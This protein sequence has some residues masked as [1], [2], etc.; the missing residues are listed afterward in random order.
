[1]SSVAVRS[2][3][4]PPR[5]R[6]AVQ[7]AHLGSHPLDLFTKRPWLTR[8]VP[9]HRAKTLSWPREGGGI[10]KRKITAHVAGSILE[11]GS[12]VW[13]PEEGEALIGTQRTGI[14]KRQE[15]A[16]TGWGRTEGTGP[17]N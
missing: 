11:G 12:Q 4:E 10:Q 16:V 8:P 13:G 5:V 15:S 3:R 17:F 14:N 2:I 7:V 1:M 6:L 9:G